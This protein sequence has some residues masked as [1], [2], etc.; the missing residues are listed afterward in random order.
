MCGRYVSPDQA[1][2]EREWHI[3][4]HNQPTL[5]QPF[6]ARYNVAPQQG[7]PTNYVP[8]VREHEGGGLELVRLQWWLLPFWSKQP[9]IKYSTFNAR[10]ETMA[11]AASFRDPLKRRRCII[12][13]L[14]WYEWQEL[15][16][17]NLPWYLHGA[18]GELL[19]FAGLWD[20][21]Q[22]GA[23]VIES[24]SIIVGPSNSAFGKIHERMPFVL[25][26]D[27]AAQWLDRK[28]TDAGAAMD[29]LQTNPEDA[30]AFHRV[31]TQVSNARNQGAELIG[32][33]QA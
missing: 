28:L 16:S 14:G 15:P 8:A 31:S 23:E 13:A 2:I 5:A 29:L 7:N 30:I 3:G 25:P 20:R 24:C 19:A 32:A 1:A 21:W 27:R 12:P 6:S 10:V 17:G 26:P 4:R 18:T 33:I 11:K 9:R 22:G